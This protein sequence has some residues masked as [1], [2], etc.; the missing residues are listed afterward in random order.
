MK[1]RLVAGGKQTS[2]CASEQQCDTRSTQTK[3][4]SQSLDRQYS[5]AQFTTHHTNSRG[6]I[7]PAV[8]HDWPGAVTNHVL[9]VVVETVCTWG[10]NRETLMTKTQ[11]ELLSFEKTPLKEALEGI[12]RDTTTEHLLILCIRSHQPFLGPP[13]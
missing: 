11:N 8:L 3:A 4:W 5:V 1:R 13:C 2:H 12:R 6:D 7:K 10:K 9:Q